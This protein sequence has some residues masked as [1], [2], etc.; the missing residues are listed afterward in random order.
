MLG[1]VVN[2]HSRLF[3]VDRVG[4]NQYRAN[5]GVHISQPHMNILLSQITQL[6]TFHT[7]SKAYIFTIPSSSTLFLLLSILSAEI[8]LF[9]RIVQIYRGI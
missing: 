2:H 8:R 7:N 3:V 5:I 9:G 4:M 6:V 1:F